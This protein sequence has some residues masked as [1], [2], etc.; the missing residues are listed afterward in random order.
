MLKVSFTKWLLDNR[1]CLKKKNA[2]LYDLPLDV[3]KGW[4]ARRRL[5]CIN[6]NT[7]FS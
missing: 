2:N 6:D 5:Y 1:R 7:V 4:F 3:K